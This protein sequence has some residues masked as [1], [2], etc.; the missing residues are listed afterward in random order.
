MGNER[1]HQ[2]TKNGGCSVRFD[3]T[4]SKNVTYHVMYSTFSVSDEASLYTLTIGGLF[5]YISI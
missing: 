3:I 1:L 4:G 2:L 5:K